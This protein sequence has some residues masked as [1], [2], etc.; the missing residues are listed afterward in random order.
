[1]VGQQHWHLVGTRVADGD[2]RCL[3][4]AICAAWAP[5]LIE[6]AAMEPGAVVRRVGP[7]GLAT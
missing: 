3:I 5:T 6:A 4:P 7:G 2:E 1:M